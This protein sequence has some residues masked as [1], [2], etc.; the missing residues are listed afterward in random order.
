MLRLLLDHREQRIE[1]VH[2]LLRERQCLLHPDVRRVDRLVH[3]LHVRPHRRG[4]IIHV[5]RDTVRVVH[6]RCDVVVHPLEQVIDPAVRPPRMKRHRDGDHRQRQQRDRDDSARHF[7]DPI[8]D[9]PVR[10]HLLHEQR[11]SGGQGSLD[12]QMSNGCEHTGHWAL[13]RVVTALPVCKGGAK[14]ARLNAPP[15]WRVSSYPLPAAAATAPPTEVAAHGMCAMALTGT[16]EAVH[17]SHPSTTRTRPA[18]S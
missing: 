15:R 7:G 16:R 17:S 10:R 18:R 4:H 5:V 14:H 8:D 11:V 3:L 1:F 6:D 9:T 2:P 13:A 12:Q